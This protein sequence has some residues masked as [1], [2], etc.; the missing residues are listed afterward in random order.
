MIRVR[1]LRKTYHTRHE[2]VEAVRD[3]SFDVADGE[4]YTLLGP[5]GCGK[6]TI[7]RCIAG[8]ERPD[9]GTIFLDGATMFAAD[10]AIH[11]PPEKR[12]IGMVF[13]SYA[14]WPHMSVFDN[15]AFPLRQSSSR[16]PRS[17]L[18]PRVRS[19]LEMVRLSGLEKRN[20][21]ELSGGQQQRLA[22]ARALVCEPKLLLLDEPLS[23]LDAKLRGEMRLELRELHKRLR[24]TTLYV[25][26][27][28]VEALSMSNRVAVVKEGRI[29][30]LD[31]SRAVYQQPN[32]SFVAAFMGSMN[33]VPGTLTRD[34]ESIWAIDTAIGIFHC[35]KSSEVR[36]GER[37]L[38]TIQPVYVV[39]HE[40][41]KEGINTVRGKVILSIFSGDYVEC[42]FKVGDQV[43]YAR[44]HPS[45]E[46]Q[47]GQEVCIELPAA[48]CIAV[49]PAE[50]SIGGEGE[51]QRLG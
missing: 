41:M 44:Q 13:Q 27:D 39:V 10:E 42:Q 14:I 43:L 24:V 38:L 6:T 33:M 23:N 30:Q 51:S 7:L 48:H 2:E 50:S 21:G 29:A 11:V 47:E 25:T 26:H 49:A 3:V 19:V 9:N 1:N 45:V 37:A 28:Q 40:I 31:H 8:L 18:E 20:G 16:F 22:L 46:F 15:V 34:S 17:E 5:S 35:A 36:V 4:F 32:D 12:S